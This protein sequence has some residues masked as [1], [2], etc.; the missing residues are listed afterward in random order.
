MANYPL[1][2][3]EEERIKALKNY[4][5][6]DTLPEEQF[7]RLTELASVIC[8]VPIAL[9]SLIDE[10]RQWFKSRQGLAA[11]QTPR[12]ISFCQ[13]AITSPSVF[14]IE[15]ATKDERFNANPLVLGNPDIKFYAG[16]P[17][18]DPDGYAL[19]TLCV[20]DRVP[21][22]LNQNQLRALEIL[23][24][25]VV[26]QIVAK[27]EK[28]ELENYERL[29]NQ[30]SDI[31]C[32]ISKD[33]LFKKINPAFIK[34]LGWEEKDLIDVPF[35]D[36]IHPDDA[37]ASK[38]RVDNLRKGEKELQTISRFRTKDNTYKILQ[39]S[40][41]TDNVSGNIY[42]IA[43]DISKL[44]E[45]DKKLRL[46]EERWKFA[47]ENSGDGLWDW[48]TA[49]NKTF[50]SDKWKKVLGHEPDEIGDTL[51]EWSTR[52]HPDDLA[53]CIEALESHFRGETPIYSKEFR[54]RCKDGGYKWILARGKVI[55][56]TSDKKP[57]RVVG[58]HTDLTE[59][60]RA[61]DLI[62]KAKEQAEAANVAKSDFLANMSHEIR[63]PL[64]GVIGFTDLLLRTNLDVTQVQYMSAVYQSANSLLDIIN[65][66]LDF[67]KIEAG[68]LELDIEKTDLLELVN[69]VADVITYQAHQ[70]KLEV[71]LNIAPDISRFIWADPIRIRQVLVNLLGNSVKFTLQGEIEL[72][73][74]ILS[75]SDEHDGE[76]NFRFSVRD[77]GI[78]IL[79]KNQQKIFEAFSQ[80]DAS[81]TRKYGGT[82]LGLTISNKLLYLMGS[83][84]ELVSEPGKGTTFYFDIAFKSMQGDPIEWENID[85]IENILIVDDNTNNRIILQN[86]LA[87]KNIACDM[88][89]NGV[90]ALEKLK[91]GKKYDAILMDYQMPQMDGI[92]T[93]RNI[94]MNIHLQAKEQPIILLYS[95]S[96]DESI[97]IACRELEVQQRLVKPIKIRQLFDSLSRISTKTSKNLVPLKNG[98]EYE[99][100]NKIGGIITI[101]IAEDNIVNMFLAKT[102]INSVLPSAIIIEATDGKEAISQFK[103]E[104]PDIIFI[105][106]QMP[107]MN[108]YEATAAIREVEASM[109][110]RVPIIALTA[111][112]VKGEKEK[113]LEAGMDDYI[114]K[115]IVKGAIEKAL[116]YWLASNKKEDTTHHFDVEKLQKRLGN[117]ENIYKQFLLLIKNNLGQPT[118]DMIEGM[119]NCLK[120]KDLSGIRTIA[121][122]I[123]GTALSAC[124]GELVELSKKIEQEQDFENENIGKLIEALD[125]EVIFLKTLIE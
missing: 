4:N 28:N 45:A 50:Y 101:L 21:K 56:W 118:T 43:H 106:V 55:D 89:E 85:H 25:E 120:R 125:K 95:S 54:M 119:R 31:I 102:I 40:A 92:E 46:S 58:I 68:K 49:T 64:N 103:K 78:G 42:A 100:I 51:E 99:L 69:Q 113:C 77:T 82:G 14:E 108:G 38:E 111:G 13:Y 3:N 117:N 15:D 94:R 34:S 2:H 116:D 65:D 86:M 76:T 91:S 10:D 83:K 41:S 80:E 47:L 124:F 5:I 39:W 97:N 1:P 66:I 104:N 105:D 122:K 98:V 75:E 79:P 32:L 114:S 52:V 24:Q 115:P 112:I 57:L 107:E 63:T 70:K 62:V 71:L 48:N 23:A 110:T 27:K 123:K 33:G 61:E 30:S 19:G 87:I 36:F 16:H 67:S 96:D 88:A 121:H 53:D 90:V 59:R 8:N 7:D 93:I 17:L 29:F 37:K 72:K 35:L 60:K 74:A 109:G 18:V 12:N 81:T 84:L 26:M 44:R 22:K 6:L 11:S 9:V 20:I 73:V